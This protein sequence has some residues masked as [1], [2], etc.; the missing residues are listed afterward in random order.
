[1]VGTINSPGHAERAAGVP[2]TNDFG[3]GFDALFAARQKEAEEFYAT[4]IPKK[5]SEDAKNVM[6]QA[7]SGPGG[8]LWRNAFAPRYFLIL[9]AKTSWSPFVSLATKSLAALTNATTRPSALI[10]GKKRPESLLPPTVP[11][12][13]TLTKVVVPVLRSRAKTFRTPFV[14]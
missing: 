14:S 8:A 6:R 9:R 7:F 2:G 11:A 4:R 13:L 3:E 5:L 10:A 1:M 12:L